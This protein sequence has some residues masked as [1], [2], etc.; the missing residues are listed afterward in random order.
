MRCCWGDEYIHLERPRPARRAIAGSHAGSDKSLLAGR[1]SAS[2]ATVWLAKLSKIPLS[3][4]RCP[5]V[6]EFGK[7]GVA[8]IHAGDICVFGSARP[9]AARPQS[10]HGPLL[11]RAARPVLCASPSLFSIGARAGG[12]A[13]RSKA[14]AWKVCMRETVSRVR[15]P[16]PPPDRH[17][18]LFSVV[19]RTPENPRESRFY[20]LALSATV[21]H[22]RRHPLG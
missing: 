7:F 5:W 12:V 22:N 4:N 11:A 3:E 9:A 14:H 19:H 21:C 16:P 2:R 15:I 17:P 10:R 13:E 8:H 1:Q 6:N 18:P 20:C